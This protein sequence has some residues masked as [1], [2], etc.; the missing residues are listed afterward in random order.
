MSTEADQGTRETSRASH[1]GDKRSSSRH[2]TSRRHSHSSRTSHSRRPS[3]SR[4]LSRRERAILIGLLAFP[5]LVCVGLTAWHI[6]SATRYR[7]QEEALAGQL[8]EERKRGEE[9][10]RAG[11][12]LQ[13]ELHEMVEGR[14]PGEL[15]PIEFDQVISLERGLLKNILFTAIRRS[16][17][18]GYEYRLLVENRLDQRVQ[19]RIRILVFDRLGI[20]IGQADI[21]DSA[22]W[23]HI[24]S[25]GLASGESQSFS[26]AIDLLIERKPAYFMLMD[27][28]ER[29]PGV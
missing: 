5:W 7:T 10:A 19:P 28:A 14:L 29:V 23:E 21:Q 8:A 15:R 26:G 27:R 11:A 3:L 18:E 2:V 9:L 4:R 17:S 6:S 25:V 22:D 16:N 24:A 12:R 20:Q 1:T 13:A